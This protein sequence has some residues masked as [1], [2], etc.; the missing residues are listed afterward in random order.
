[1]RLRG[2]GLLLACAALLSACVTLRDH[3]AMPR[4][5]PSNWDDR[6]G[7]LQA[8]TRFDLQGRLAVA[9]GEQGF[10]AALRWSQRSD[11]ARLEVDGPLGVGGLRVDLERGRLPDEAVRAELEQRLGFA[12]PLE[13]LRYWMLGV[14]DPARAAEERRDADSP[15]LAA[16]TQDGWTVLYTRYARVADGDYELPQRIEVTRESVRVRLLIERWGRV[17]Q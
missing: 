11:R 14:P 7:E 17:R 15:T 10:S 6:R 1:M 9:S 4:A 16:L 5:L 12:L 2:A 8:L 13:S 3:A